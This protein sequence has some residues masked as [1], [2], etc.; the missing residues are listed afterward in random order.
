M[1]A[2]KETAHDNIFLF[3]SAQPQEP[4]PDGHRAPVLELT[5]TGSN[6]NSAHKRTVDTQTPSQ[7]IESLSLAEEGSR[8]ESHNYS[9][10][11]VPKIV[12]GGCTSISS[13][14]C[15]STARRHR[16]TINNVSTLGSRGQCPQKI[17]I[18]KVKI[19][20]GT[21]YPWYQF[22]CVNFCFKALVVYFCHGTIAD[23][24]PLWPM[25]NRPRQLLWT[26]MHFN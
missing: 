10:R 19:G 22:G 26:T 20:H 9:F 12:I 8:L 24:E 17:W 11:V 6:N 18:F 5:S 1:R 16:K 15:D 21:L 7:Y 23:P 2:L 4:T 3:P 14:L 25:Q 13:R